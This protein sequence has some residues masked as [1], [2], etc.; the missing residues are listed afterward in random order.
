M[1]E[2]KRGEQKEE[3]NPQAPI[4]INTQPTPNIIK[5]FDDPAKT[6]SIASP[7]PLR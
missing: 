7:G 3:N 6:Q 2:E 1:N 4:Q 5:T